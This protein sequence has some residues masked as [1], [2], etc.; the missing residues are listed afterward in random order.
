MQIGDKD[1]LNTIYEEDGTLILKEGEEI[2]VQE[3]Q[4]VPQLKTTWGYFGG[5]DTIEVDTRVIAATNAPLE[6]MIAEPLNRL[7]ALLESR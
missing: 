5:E 6:K 1:G 3:E 7:N 4:L 2:L